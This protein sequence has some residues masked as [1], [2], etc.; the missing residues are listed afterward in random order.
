MIK[1]ENEV[2]L[3]VL[4]RDARS[5]ERQE[6][7]HKVNEYEKER[8]KRRQDIEFMHSKRAEEER[9]QTVS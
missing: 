8:N 3:R 9:L 2:D 4:A 6:L 7:Q 5:V 1:E